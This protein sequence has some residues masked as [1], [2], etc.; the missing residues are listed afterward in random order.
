MKL[1]EAFTAQFIGC[2]QELHLKVCTGVINI[3]GGA[4]ALRY[5]I[6]SSGSRA[7]MTLI[8]E[9]HKRELRYGLAALYVVGGMGMVTIAEIL[10]L[11]QSTKESDRT[12]WANRQED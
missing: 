8:H 11:R 4:I 12:N 7:L 6:G 2:I 5:P 9:P 3:N 1:N 10:R